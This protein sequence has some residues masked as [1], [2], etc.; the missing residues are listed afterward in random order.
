M[1]AINIT[2]RNRRRA[3][4]AGLL[5]RGILY[6]IIG[7]L[8]LQIALG[9]GGGG[10][11]QPSQQGALQEVAAQ[12]FG[13]VMVLLL[14]LGLLGY[15]LWRLSQFFTEKG[16]EHNEAKAWIQRISY[17][18]RAVIYAGL[19]FV[20]FRIA[21]GSGGGGGNGQQ[22]LTARVM[23]WPGGR[24]LVG[25]VGIVIIGVALYQ[26]YQAFSDDFMDELRTEQMSPQTRVWVERIGTAGHAARAVVFSLIG[27]FVIRAAVQFDANEAVG[28]DGALQSLA[29]QPAGRWLLGFTALGLLLYGVYSIVRARY[30]DVSE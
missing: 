27:V 4:Q 18:V 14:G 19:S 21:F 23:S 20:A 12:P 8:A 3:A 10:G 13:T 26:A 5:A 9:G 30:V 28:L 15:A 17:I 25:I 16:D 1:S 29:Q 6:A 24:V 22:T 2:I 7:V 11:E